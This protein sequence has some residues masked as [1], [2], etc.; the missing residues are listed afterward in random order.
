MGYE[1]MY[2]LGKGVAQVF[3]SSGIVNTY[4][5]QLQNAGISRQKE[6][7]AYAKEL[8]NIS[9]E[10]A[11]EADEPHFRKKWEAIL[12]L[13]HKRSLSDKKEDKISYSSQIQTLK[14]EMASDAKRS[15]NENK[16]DRDIAA[17]PLTKNRYE[18]PDNFGNIL[19]ARRT[20]SIFDPAF[21]NYGADKFQAQAKPY[22]VNKNLMELANIAAKEVSTKSV[23]G[24][25]FDARYVYNEGKQLDK[26]AFITAFLDNVASDDQ[27]MDTYLKG[28]EPTPENLNDA[29]EAAFKVVENKFALKERIGGRVDEDGYQLNLYDRKRQIGLKYDKTPEGSTSALYRQDLVVRM[30]N[31]EPGS[32]EELVA[33][34][35]GKG[36]DLK[37]I[38]SNK[39]GKPIGIKVPQDDK[40]E[41]AAYTVYF[42]DPDRKQAYIKLNSLISN[43]TG[44]NVNLSTV[45]TDRG[46]KQVAGGKDVKSLKN[47]P[48]KQSNQPAQFEVDGK[49]YNIPSD[50]VSAF[51]K[52]FPK[53]K[54]K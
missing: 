22:D 3:D 19:T 14:K 7:D 12:D 36:I 10:G 1:N 6:R 4:A 11:R 52:Q 2:G 30:M 49:Q 37:V 25:G 53:A 34:A 26:G 47:E 16:T 20:T 29:A 46:R 32:G 35:K 38:T 8:E 28:L 40:K 5:R 9:W 51:I 48:A 23:E 39:T 43:M 45:M 21:S 31:N 17:M 50:K 41:V 33:A 15:V 27:A 44:E 18:M 42:N 13:N 54:R 24:D